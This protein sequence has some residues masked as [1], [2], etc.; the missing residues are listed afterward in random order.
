MLVRSRK[1]DPEGLS[2]I[3]DPSSEFF[4]PRS[5]KR[6]PDPGVIKAL[7]PI[8]DPNPQHCRRIRLFSTDSQRTSPACCPLLFPPRGED[9]SPE[10]VCS[11]SPSPGFRVP[12]AHS[13][14]QFRAV[15]TAKHKYEKISFKKP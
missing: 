5:R 12:F 8:S 10:L 14:R 6:I 3:S 2:R 13:S 4:H 15:H 1:Y 11:R 7:D 9:A